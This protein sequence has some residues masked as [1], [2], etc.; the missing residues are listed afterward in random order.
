MLVFAAGVSLSCGGLWLRS[1]WLFSAFAAVLALA[2]ADRCARRPWLAY[3]VFALC[4]AALDPVDDDQR[5]L[6][7]RCQRALVIPL[8]RRGTLSSWTPYHVGMR[9]LSDRR[10]A[11][12]F[13]FVLASGFCVALVG[14]AQWHAGT[15]GYR[16]LV[17]NLMLALVPV[18][19]RA[20]LLRRLPARHGRRTGVALVVALWLAVPPECALHGHRPRPS[21]PDPGR[22]ALVRRRDDRGVCQHRSS[23]RAG[24]GVPRPRS[25]TAR[26]GRVLGWVRFCRCSASA[27]SASC[28]AGSG[29]STAGTCRAA[30]RGSATCSPRIWPIR[31]RA[32][33]PSSATVGYAAF[34]A[35][36]YVV[37]YALSSLRLRA[38]A[39]GRAAVSKGYAEG[40]AA[41]EAERRLEE[42][43]AGPPPGEAPQRAAVY[44]STH[45]SRSATFSAGSGRSIRTRCSRRAR[46][47]GSRSC[48][49]A[50]AS[51]EPLLDA[52]L[53]SAYTAIQR[54]LTR[55]ERQR[56]RETASEGAHDHDQTRSPA[57][58]ADGGTRGSG[59][60]A[61]RRR[62]GEPADRLR[63]SGA[64][65][66]ACSSASPKRLDRRFQ[67]FSSRCLVANA[68]EKCAKVADRFVK[69]LDGCRAR[70]RK[71]EERIKAK[72]GAANPPARCSNASQ[73]TPAID[74]LL[75][76]IASDETA[77]K[78]A[79]P[80]AGSA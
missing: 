49:S 19:A 62:R 21:R 63:A 4:G 72:C 23:A 16:F 29:A 17:W 15:N 36:A 59:R 38:R 46:R 31:S 76:K 13:A 33:A 45:A 66:C 78:A 5:S 20:A 27:A 80:N 50:P 60:V 24:L 74:E 14:R 9:H 2:L 48:V 51:P 39:E 44:G 8:G 43:A 32:A 42:L 71:V 61:R 22:T 11:T 77:I 41:E 65:G 79:F 26:L 35:L 67:A 53:R 37:L 28:S 54:S 25:C 47:G 52:V 73:V 68:P 56:W 64:P 75:A 3:V 55:G 7:G 34:L 18:P 57:R 6:S 40:P 30:R 58:R 70:L 1:A 10:V 69:R 12:M